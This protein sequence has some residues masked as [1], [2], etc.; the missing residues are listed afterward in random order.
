MND[1]IRYRATIA[2]DNVEDMYDAANFYPYY[3][4]GDVY[5]EDEY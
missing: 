1:V 3:G 4:L 5:D 2:S